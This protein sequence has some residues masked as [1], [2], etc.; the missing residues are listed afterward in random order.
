MKPTTESEIKLQIVANLTSEAYGQ[1]TRQ[2]ITDNAT[3]QLPYYEP[4]FEIEDDAGT[5]H[6]SVIDGEGNAVSYT[7]TINF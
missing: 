3:H 1:Q 6:L 7:G 5:A 2:K 4:A